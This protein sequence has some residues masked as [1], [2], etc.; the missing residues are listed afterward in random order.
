MKKYMFMYVFGG[1]KDMYR[2]LRYE[3][4]DMETTS[5]YTIKLFLNYL[6]ETFRGASEIYLV[7]QRPGLA[8]EFQEAMRRPSPETCIAFKDYVSK[9]G[10]KLM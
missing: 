5:L 6:T 2:P 8:F 1:E 7:E 10:I 4:F 3:R 9:I